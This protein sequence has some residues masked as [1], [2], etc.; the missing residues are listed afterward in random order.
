MLRLMLFR[1]AKAD[2]PIDLVDHERPLSL[3]GHQQ[4][5]AMG[6]YIQTEGLA[7]DLAIVSSARRTQETWQEAIS[8]GAL[9]TITAIEP[10]IYESSVDDLLDVIRAQD[11]KHRCIMLVG[12]NPGMERLTTW[13]AG[14]SDPIALERLKREFVPGGLAVIDLRIES[15]SAL[16]SQNGQLE[17]FE[18]PDTV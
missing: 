6:H 2:R 5:R 9:D 17:R 13:L 4:A 10:R 7:P 14:D 3:R 1:H 18:T 15:W 8:A 11:S 16:E 12:H